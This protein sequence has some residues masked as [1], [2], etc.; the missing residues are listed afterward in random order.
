MVKILSKLRGGDLRSIG[1]VG[2]ADLAIKE[3]DV[4][5]RVIRAIE[6][7][8]QTGSP[9]IPGL[10]DEDPVQLKNPSQKNK[11]PETVQK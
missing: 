5:T 8:A 7:L 6:K 4:S 2:E 1:K 9:A 11:R 10:F 3:A